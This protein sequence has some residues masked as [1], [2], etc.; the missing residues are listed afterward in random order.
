MRLSVMVGLALHLVATWALVLPGSAAETLPPEQE[1]FF[2]KRVRP[3]LAAHCQ[4]CHG[5]ETQEAHLR[6]DSR[7]GIERGGDAGKVIVPGEPDRSR[8]IAAVRYNGDLQMPP[9]YKLSAKDFQTLVEW[10]KIGAPWPA[11]A[12]KDSPPPSGAKP[13][14]VAMTAA[15]AGH[16]SYQP[17]RK[18]ALPAVENEA[19]C[20]TPIDRFILA[21]LEQQ[22]LH[23]SAAADRSTLI[24]RLS[25]DLIGLPP[26]Y[27]EVEA[28]VADRSPAAVEKVIDRL[29]ASPHYGER[30]G[31]HWLDIAR[32]ADTKGYVFQEERRYPFAYTYRDY[33]VQ[34]LNEDLPFDQ[35][36]IEQLAADKLPPRDEN[37]S[38]AAMGFLT[39]G[40]RFSN[41]IHD[42]I[43]DR[44]D[45]VTRGMLGLT[46]T[47]A[48]CHDHKYDPIPTADYYSLYAVF[49]SS[50]EPKELPLVGKPEDGPAYEKY[51]Q[52]LARLQQE[53][54]G[55][56]AKEIDK[57]RAELRG[58]SGE[59]LAQAVVDRLEK[60]DRVDEFLSLSP[61]ET[62]PQLVRRWR[63]YLARK[64]KQADPVFAL[65]HRF[66]SWKSADFA[67]EATKLIDEL[68]TAAANDTSAAQVNARLRQAILDQPPQSLLDVI[69]LYGKLL[70]EVD[71][72]WKAAL[73]HAAEAKM[74]PPTA[75]ADAAD[76][77]LR[78]VLYGADSPAMFASEEAL[79]LFDRAT[80]T[81]YTGLKKKVDSFKA[82]SP[83][84]PPRAMVLNDVEKP[85][86]VRIFL[87]GNPARPGAEVP[88]QYLEVLAGDHR[89]PFTDGSGRLE[90]AR[91]IASADNPLTARVIVNR[92]WQHHFGA[93][94]VTTPSDFG[95]RSE[96]PSHPELLDY[97]AATLMDEGWSL[98]RLHRQ[99][100]LSSVYQQSSDDR[101]E[102]GAADP[103][104]RLLWRANRRRLEFEPLRDAMLA[105]SGQLDRTLGGRPVEIAKA[106]YSKRRTLY[107]FI[108]R[109]DLPDM[110]RVFDFASPDVSTEQRPTT[111]VPQ[112]ALFAMNSPF[113]LDQAR[114]L[115]AR[116][117]EP[118]PNDPET[119][120][121]ALYRLAL[122]RQPRA[123]E[124]AK[125]LEFIT[126]QQAKPTEPGQLSPWELLAQ[127]LLLTNEFAFVD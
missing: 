87:R 56:A 42:I 93:G 108:D 33:V 126:A 46:V 77:Q 2:E 109:Q 105:V 115:A 11:E 73:E 124:Q 28:F 118:A 37:R 116:A 10:V 71:A 8:L 114:S 95:A 75:L 111:T 107:G 59:Y 121:A 19:W 69:K 117:N 63:D 94:L 54:D 5:A 67:S 55:F 22:K 100:L 52:Q 45:V 4:K 74:P 127:V 106:P 14:A 64:A 103:E 23:P 119:R 38:L 102:A 110:F 78:Q 44:I 86:N 34:S 88:R 29:L 97:L 25:F 3:L 61:G 99:I 62:R 17:I 50:T 32:Y 80:R 82:S 47:C 51:Q 40:R 90:L 120:I 20:R 1:E 96:P 123:D 83:A 13:P 49:N 65:W 15:R 89:Q 48:R 101:P 84:A 30:W 113:V 6:L 18:P 68:K 98:K 85:T 79:R 43:D 27:E 31:R 9:D 39:V 92:V 26:S 66:V 7:Q 91:A 35:F 41:N 16:W 72:Q 24:R 12:V 70:A 36:I 122:S 21:K 76:E 112:Q 125:A 104:N 58:Q 81:K 60:G 57:L 53:F